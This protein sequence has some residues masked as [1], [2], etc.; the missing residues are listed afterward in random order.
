MIYILN[1]M[2]MEKRF[3]LFDNFVFRT[4]LF[5]FGMTYND[6]LFSS[7]IFNEALLLA[8]PDFYHEKGK[9]DHVKNDSKMKL[10]LLK[11]LTRSATRCT[12]FGL[13]AGCSVGKKGDETQITLQDIIKYERTTRLDMNYMC[14]LIQCI[15]KK[16]EIRTR[17]TYFTNDSIY[18]LG[19][20]YRYVEY[21][22]FGVRRIHK[23]SSVEITDYLTCILNNAS[24]GKKYHE[25]VSLLVD[26]DISYDEASDF[27]DELIEAQLLKS[28]LEITVTG[29]NS[30]NTLIQKLSKID[31]TIPL[32][33]QLS[34]INNLLK[35]IDNSKLGDTLNKYDI[36]KKRIQNLEVKF[37]PK[38][39]FQTDLLKPT[40]HSTISRELEESFE[41]LLEFLNKI[42]PS[43]PHYA[44]QEFKKSFYERYEEREVPLLNVLDTELG[45]GYLQNEMADAPNTLLDDIPYRMA[46]YKD[47]ANTKNTSGPLQDLMLNK[48]MECIRNGEHIITLVDSDVA[49]FKA[50]WDDLPNT[51]YIMCNIHGTKNNTPLVNIKAVGGSCAAN[52]LGRFCHLHEDIEYL[53]KEITKKD[54]YLA[55][56]KILAEIVHLP[57]SRI[58]NILFRPVLRDYEIHYLANSAVKDDF[59]I[60]VSDLLISIRN[61]KIF[62][63]SKKLNKEIIPRLT[64]AHNYSFNALPVYHF[65]CEMQYQE[66]RGSLYFD[67]GNI[68]NAFDYRPRVMYKN[69][70]LSREQWYISESR[71]KSM[72]PQSVRDYVKE[73]Q[74]SNFVTIADGDNE[75]FIDFSNDNLLELFLYNLKKKKQLWVTEFLFSTE[76]SIVNDASGN[77]YCNEFIFPFYKK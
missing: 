71:I 22:Y 68:F 9:V 31:D 18:R 52:L 20:M 30:L 57:E 56:D 72:C 5:N 76:D 45:I 35:E 14:A 44:L 39:L 75:Q 64:T 62:L 11:Y 41:S 29:E 32:V 77:F 43:T 58:G 61:G 12:P 2:I 1:T 50:K 47:S 36:I 19:G 17:L 74:I 51:L 38:F 24:K 16:N 53:S 37:D 67:W 4:P 48:Y 27:I 66:L 23:I 3:I 69:F 59:S 40:I 54:Q 25:L 28:E 21:Y 65:L 33:S 34:D 73:K 63:R 13:F 46:F 15:E 6:D 7:D 10:S 55:G 60:P 8:S 49:K 42:T 26:E 70:I